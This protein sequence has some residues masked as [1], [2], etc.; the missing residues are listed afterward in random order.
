M[1][2]AWEFGLLAAVAIAS[3]AIRYPSFLVYGPLICLLVLRVNLSFRLTNWLGGISYSLYL[4]HGV[5]GLWLAGA[6]T[7]LLK[8]GPVTAFA[9]GT[10]GAIAFAAVISRLVERPAMRASKAL[11]YT[12]GPRRRA[13]TAPASPA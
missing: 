1:S 4:F 2:G 9:L 10:A 6:L 8:V 3:I 7:V 12:R 11:H 5:F 13:G